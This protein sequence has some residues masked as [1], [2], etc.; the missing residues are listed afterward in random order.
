MSPIS[1]M[2][3]NEHTLP[4]LGQSEVLSVQHSV[5]EPIPELAQPP[6]EGAKGPSSVRRQ[7]TGDILPNQPAGTQSLSQP[8]ILE[9]ECTTLVVQ[10][11]SESSA[12]E[13]L[14]GR[15]AHEKVD[16]LMVTS[17]DLGEVASERHVKPVGED[18]TREWRDLREER[19]SPAERAPRDGG[20]LDPRTDGAEDHGCPAT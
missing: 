10:S 1:K 17:P 7:H 19:G 15:A 5:G 11:A 14:A 12:R 4:S 6:E 8:E 2:A 18:G 3:D 20:G 16:W 13:R 9:H